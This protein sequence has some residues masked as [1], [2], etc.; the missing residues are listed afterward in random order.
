[1]IYVLKM[2]VYFLSFGWEMVEVDVLITN[3]FPL[4]D[5]EKTPIFHERCL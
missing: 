1:M 4:E 3:L 5:K 2:L